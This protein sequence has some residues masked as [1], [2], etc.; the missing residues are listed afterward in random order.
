MKRHSEQY[1]TYREYVDAGLDLLLEHAAQY[2]AHERTIPVSLSNNPQDATPIFFTFSD[3]MLTGFVDDPDSLRKPYDVAIRYGFRGYSRG[4]K[5][6]VFLLR[7]EDEGLHRALDSTSPLDIMQVNQ[8]LDMQGEGL[9]SLLR[10]K[11]VWHQ[12]DGKRAVGLYNP[13]NSRAI[14]LDFANY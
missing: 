14:F 2:L 9:D 3:K 1:H 10:V 13:R 12:P 6:G 5:N 4:N 8:D 11:I 7:K